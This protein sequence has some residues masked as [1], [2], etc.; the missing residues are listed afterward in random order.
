MTDDVLEGVWA[1]RAEL[2]AELGT[3]MRSIVA[4]L[5]K[6]DAADDRVVVRHPPRRP[7]GWKPPLGDDAPS[8]DREL[9]PAS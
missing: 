4:A 1:A 6:M 7:E 5:Q 2:A 9:T 8:S 3:D